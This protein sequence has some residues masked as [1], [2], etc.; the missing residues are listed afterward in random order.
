M[1][2]NLLQN[3]TFLFI[4][5]LTLINETDL[6]RIKSEVVNMIKKFKMM[7]AGLAV[8]CCLTSMAGCVAANRTPQGTTTPGTITRQGT[9]LSQ[10]LTRGMNPN[11]M[12]PGTGFG[13]LTSN[14]GTTTTPGMI[15]TQPLAFDVKKADNIVKNMG[16]IDGSR[17]IRAIV[18]GNTAL[19]SYT[20]SG[21]M[22]NT[23]ATKSAIVKKVKSIDRTITNVV[24]TESAD[25]IGRMNRLSNDIKSNKVGSS[26]NNIFN[27]LVQK[28]K[29]S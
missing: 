22:R 13:N 27:Q 6:R 14:Q 2:L 7:A 20:P 4:Y 29:T 16:N 21:T 10:Q 17:D 5:Y 1:I 28:V 26:L 15:N 8:A 23:L 25:I 18:N 9:N 11:T 12:I 3:Y 24:V 19:V